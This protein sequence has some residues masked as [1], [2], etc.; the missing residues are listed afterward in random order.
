MQLD[1]PLSIRILTHNIR[2]ATS[3]PFK[4]EKPW[5]ERKHLVLNELIFH[6]RHNA[7]S[8]ICLQEVLHVQLEDVLSGLN[9]HGDAWAYIGVGRDDGKQAGEYSPIFYRP[10]IWKLETWETVWLSETPEVPSKGWDA[11]SIRIVTVGVFRHRASRKTVLAMSTHLDDQGS[12]SRYE[13]AKLI[14]R[15]IDGYLHKFKDR[16]SGLFLAGDFNSEVNQEAYQVFIDQT[17]PLVD[18]RDQIKPDERYGNEI[19]YTGFGYEGERETRI[20]YIL[21][22]PKNEQGFPWTVKQY[23]V[24]PNKFDDGVFSS[25]HRAVVADGLVDC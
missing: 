2:Y 22:G 5:P 12:K 18:A 4:G 7:E 3:R 13:S 8:F 11:A 10:D 1:G 23:G 24:L 21:V 16:I 14:L 15:T 25:D 17:S 6:T 9:S 20:D 19:T